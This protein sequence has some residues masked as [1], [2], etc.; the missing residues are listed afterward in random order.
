MNHEAVCPHFRRVVMVFCDAA[1]IRKPVPEDQLASLG[2]CAEPDHR[3]CPL[4]AAENS[5]E[6]GDAEFPGRG[7]ADAPAAG[8]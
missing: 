4:F 7:A 3:H 1:P 6:N 8:R 5:A 2:P